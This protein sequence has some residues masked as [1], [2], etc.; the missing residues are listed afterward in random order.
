MKK[1]EILGRDKMNNDINTLADLYKL[2][3]PALKSKKREMHDLK[4]LYITEQD[5]WNYI[6]ENIWINSTNLTLSDMVSDI[7]S[8]DND[9]IAAF[10]ATQ[11]RETRNYN[12]D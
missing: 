9:K 2:L 1:K 7:L 5:I 10:I 3:L 4:Y 12:E 6:K 8:T 11:I